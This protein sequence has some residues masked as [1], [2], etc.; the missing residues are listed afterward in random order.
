MS[1]GSV[2]LDANGLNIDK[3]VHLAQTPTTL[4][5]HSHR[6]PLFAYV[7]Y[8][9]LLGKGGFN[10]NDKTPSTDSPTALPKVISRRSPEQLAW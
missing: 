6:S 8:I 5:H 2:L 1:T 9:M 4:R 10:D 3:V 7:M